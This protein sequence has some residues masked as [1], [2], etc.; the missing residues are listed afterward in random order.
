MKFVFSISGYKLLHGSSNE[1]GKCFY[2]T[3]G[4]HISLK[5]SISKIALL[6]L[7]G[8][9]PFFPLL[10]CLFNLYRWRLMFS[11]VESKWRGDKVNFGL[12]SSCIFNDGSSFVFFRY[13]GSNSS[14]T[15][16]TYTHFRPKINRQKNQW[17]HKYI[18]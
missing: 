11:V 15:R 3:G 18:C 17:R 4:P 16:T 6:M 7:L 12:L 8:W 2:N 14:L 1:I 9:H 13:C 10:L 5:W